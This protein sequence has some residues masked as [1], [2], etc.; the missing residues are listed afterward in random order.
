M[1]LSAATV[2]KEVR[3]TADFAGAS[4]TT[5]GGFVSVASGTDWSTQV[6]AQYSVTDGVTTASATITSAN[7][8]R[9]GRRRQHHLS[10]RRYGKCCSELVSNHGSQLGDLDHSRSIHR[11][12]DRH[13]RYAQDWRGTGQSRA[14]ISDHGGVRNE[15]MGPL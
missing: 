8:S 15:V 11:A 3:N 12:Y 4:D 6:S 13:G 5:G 2:C 9:H 14:S 10:I 1:A 7:G